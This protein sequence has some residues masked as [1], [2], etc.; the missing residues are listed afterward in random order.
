ML[1]AEQ[2]HEANVSMH[3]ED[4]EAGGRSLEALEAALSLAQTAGQ[5]GRD[6]R[7]VVEGKRHAVRLRKQQSSSK[8]EAVERWMQQELLL[9]LDGGPQEALEA[10]LKAGAAA[11]GP[12]NPSVKAARELY[13]ARRAATQKQAWE[14]Q[15]SRHQELVASACAIRD[16]ALLER[17]LAAAQEAGL[18]LGH[19]VVMRGKQQLVTLRKELQLASEDA[20]RTE[21]ARR[22]Q[23]VTR[24]AEQSLD[25]IEAD[26]MAA[27]QAQQ[28]RSCRSSPGLLG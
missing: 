21:C 12:A 1:V 27:R 3:L 18:G 26:V 15:V 8:Q 20:W 9:A 6:H 13:R 23:E 11:L 7:I 5:L 10:A 24:Q 28:L 22:L 14:A 19:P 25:R 17:Q 2:W 16:V 4:A